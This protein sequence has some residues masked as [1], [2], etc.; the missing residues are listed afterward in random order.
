M[1][2]SYWEFAYLPRYYSVYYGSLI[3]IILP[4]NT[5]SITWKTNYALR[6]ENRDINT[7]YFKDGVREQ[8]DQQVVRIQNK[9]EK[10]LTGY[11]EAK[12]KKDKISWKRCYSVASWI[13]IWILS[14]QYWANI[15]Y[16][17]NIG[18]MNKVKIY[19]F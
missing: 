4:T 6:A 7:I 18:Y 1:N 12:V 8:V 19:A 2:I 9:W 11:K 3:N 15:K 10:D 5:A 13:M 17:R 14:V 16:L